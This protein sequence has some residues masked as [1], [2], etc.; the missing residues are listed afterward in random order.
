[1]SF[2]QGFEVRERLYESK[3]S[4]VLRA[5]RD[6]DGLP[7]V[8][9]LLKNDYPTTAELAHYRRE[10]DITQSLDLPGVIRSYELRRHEKTL[11]IVFEDFGAMS[12]GRLLR[13]RPMSL[14]EFLET[15]IQVAVALGQVHRAQIIHKDINP[16]NLVIKPSTGEV[17]IIDFGISTRFSTEHPVVKNPEVL[18]GTLAYMSPEQTGRMNRSLDYR[19]DLY[20]LGAPSTRCSPGAARSTRTT[21]WSWCMPD[22][23]EPIAGPRRIRTCPLALSKIVIKLLAKN[24]EDRYQ[25]ALASWPRTCEAPRGRRRLANEDFELGGRDRSRTGSRCQSGCTA[26]TASWRLLETFERSAAGAPR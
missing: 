15:A 14:D 4:L 5:A 21:A 1:M 19:S 18:E 6:D 22:C 11:L 7:V 20:S 10:F 3:N 8:I 23:A 2:I 9:K 16:A 26:A 13:D 12:V 17:K 24:A 25:S